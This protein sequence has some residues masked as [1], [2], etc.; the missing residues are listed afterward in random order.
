MNLKQFGDLCRARR[1]TST[2]SSEETQIAKNLCQKVQTGTAAPMGVRNQETWLILT[3]GAHGGDV[4]SGSSGGVSVAHNHQVIH[5]VDYIV[6]AML[7]LY[8]LLIRATP[9]TIWK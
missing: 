5:H 7:Y 3:D 4:P 9:Y 1:T 6:P 8:Y 2:L